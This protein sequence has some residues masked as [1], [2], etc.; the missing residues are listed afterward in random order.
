MVWSGG[1]GDAG[2]LA[3]IAAVAQHAGETRG[4]ADGTTEG[5]SR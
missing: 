2:T 4:L 1:G 3:K 5:T